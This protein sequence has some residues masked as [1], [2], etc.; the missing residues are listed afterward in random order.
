MSSPA[1]RAGLFVLVVG[2]AELRL[3][4]GNA[5]KIWHRMQK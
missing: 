1:P 3:S 4:E 2:K 5:A